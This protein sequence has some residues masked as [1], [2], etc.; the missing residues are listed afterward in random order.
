MARDDVDVDFLDLLSRAQRRVTRRLASVLG[1]YGSSV[2]DWRVL[3][4]LHDGGGRSMSAIA[5]VTMLP[6][7]TLT[8]RI[9]RMVADN[10]VHRRLD[11]TDRRRVLVVLSPRGNVLH[12]LLLPHV[13]REQELIAAAITRNT[14]LGEFTTALEALADAVPQPA[15]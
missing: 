2:D 7:P 6:P 9:D 10:L 15:G 14:N 12:D 3:S 1:A 4:L 5:A 8:K 13:E 11:E